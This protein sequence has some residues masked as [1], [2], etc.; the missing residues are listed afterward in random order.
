[1]LAALA[2][3]PEC[4]VTE[5]FVIIMEQFPPI[6]TIIAEFS[7]INYIGRDY[8]VNFPSCNMHERAYKQRS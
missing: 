6:S 5:S 3:V 8:R 1:M 7:Y 2:F 4:D